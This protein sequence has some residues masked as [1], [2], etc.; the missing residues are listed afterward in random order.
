MVTDGSTPKTLVVTALST[1][2]ADSDHDTRS[3][4]TASAGS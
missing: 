2:D 4:G 3:S 1:P